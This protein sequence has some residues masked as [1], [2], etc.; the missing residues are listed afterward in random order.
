MTTD[1]DC[2]PEDVA[3]VLATIKEQAITSAPLT[4]ET[5]EL[6][7]GAF[8][9]VKTKAGTY[10]V[11]EVQ[12][13]SQSL[14][15]RP[16][17]IAVTKTNSSI[18]FGGKDNAEIG[19]EITYH[20]YFSTERGSKNNALSCTVPNGLTL[21]PDRTSVTKNNQ[22][23]MYGET[24]VEKWNETDSSPDGGKTY[25]MK[26]SDG[27]A[28]EKVA[29]TVTCVAKIN[30]KAEAGEALKIEARQSY[31]DNE[32]LAEPFSNNCYTFGFDVK[33]TD[34]NGD[35]LS[36][37]GFTL[38]NSS[39][40]FYTLPTEENNDEEERFKTVATNEQAPVVT[41]D[42][43]GMIHFDGL[44]EGNYILE[45]TAAVSGYEKVSTPLTI[46]IA[47]N[48]ALSV[49]ESSFTVSNDQKNQTQYG[50]LTIVNYA[51]ELMPVPETGGSGTT[52]FYVSGGLLMLSAGIL[53]LLGKRKAA[54]GNI[55]QI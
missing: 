53:L 5:P 41:T 21:L 34:K 33:V 25:T 7:Y 55:R 49:Q 51:E 26:F 3:G 32:N 29:W 4:S 45:Q 48:G 47:D 44:A 28:G 1:A 18:T 19:Q 52:F 38:K 8:V 15:E 54:S 23:S 30:E 42:K 2:S 20:I 9:L 46:K 43:S 35:S 39:G 50:T 13:S 37:A 10:F 40:K 12:D 16:S 24:G 36:G 6:A 27:V 14:F 22:E 17:S 31:G 11:S